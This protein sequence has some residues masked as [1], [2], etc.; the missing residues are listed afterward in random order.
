MITMDVPRRQFTNIVE[1]SVNDKKG[2]IEMSDS[3]NVNDQQL[4]T[5]K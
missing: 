4:K 5:Y 3:N 1:N 2:E